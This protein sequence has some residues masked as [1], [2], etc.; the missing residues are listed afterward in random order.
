MFVFAFYFFYSTYFAEAEGGGGGQRKTIDQLTI[1]KIP[2]MGG[3]LTHFPGGGGGGFKLLI[4]IETH[5]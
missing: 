4:P 5:R 1:I 3:G 2:G